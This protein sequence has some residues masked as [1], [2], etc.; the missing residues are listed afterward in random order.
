MKC[1][2]CR[3]GIPHTNSVCADFQELP[4]I[5][6]NELEIRA[7]A[8]RM[9]SGWAKLALALLTVGAVVLCWVL[10]FIALS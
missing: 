6:Q 3:N 10:W 2:Y 4:E 5:I 8:D 9:R 7:W 1:Y